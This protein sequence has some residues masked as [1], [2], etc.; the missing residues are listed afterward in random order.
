MELAQ[1]TGAVLIGGQ[2]VRILQRRYS[3]RVAEL[4]TLGA[5]TSV[6]VDFLGNSKQA[7]YLAE[8][9]PDSVVHV[10]QPFD[11]ITPNSAVIEGKIGG[12]SVTIDFMS[13]IIWVKEDQLKQR[14][15]TLSAIG[16]DGSE[17]RILCMHPLDCLKNRL[18]NINVLKRTDPMAITTAR[19]AVYITDGFIDEL[20]DIGETKD[21]Q[22]ALQELEYIIR[23]K[24]AGQRSY[25]AFGIDPRVI[26]KKYATDS[27][28]DPRY[29]ELTL[30]GML[31]RVSGYR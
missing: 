3:A 9:L 18:G 2:S 7:N 24:C 6:D 20:L 22:N 29:R 31:R 13:Q 5:I 21:A 4:K 30:G 15:L 23:D 8:G 11:H 27:R 14:F 1:S 28:L 26:I 19:A 12:Q 25:I 16:N 10:P 17:I